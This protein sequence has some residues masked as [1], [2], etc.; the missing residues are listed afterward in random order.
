VRMRIVG[1]F[2]KLLNL[3]C[4][5]FRLLNFVHKVGKPSG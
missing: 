4:E 5:I 2:C 1:F 3:S